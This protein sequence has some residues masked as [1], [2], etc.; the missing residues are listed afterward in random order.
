VDRPLDGCWLDKDGPRV[1]IVCPNC[2]S[3]YTVAD[4]MLGPNGRKVKCASCQNV[5]LATPVEVPAV[6]TNDAFVEADDVDKAM[7][8]SDDVFA[9]TNATDA[10]DGSDLDEE[11][12]GWGEAVVSGDDGDLSSGPVDAG[13]AAP[14]A[15]RFRKVR[16]KG[17]RTGPSAI[18]R[19]V[20]RAAKIAAPVGVAIGLA[21]LIIAVPQRDA[22]VRLIPDLAP[23]YE[24]V[25]LDVNVRG[26][27][28]SPF[29][30][31]RA[32][33]AG[34]TVLRIEGTM[35]NAD[36]ETR[37]VA[38]LRLALLAETGA[39]LFVWRVDPPTSDLLPEQSVPVFSELTAPP[40]TV[41]SV[42]VRF[43]QDGERLPGQIF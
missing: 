36:D 32:L 28:F 10:D 33:V 6:A 7:A 2:S 27:E 41:A 31:E 20:R 35:R 26:I 12:E 38:P 1:K 30:A 25:G 19:I 21:G 37:T 43:L 9:K 13:V 24:M 18:E 15:R 4:D 23:L 22:V 8:D 3:H 42:S 14:R 40:E 16:L 39:E 11:M 29:T 17:Q 34:L 5:W